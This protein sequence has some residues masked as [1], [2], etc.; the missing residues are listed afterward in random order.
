[1][2]SAPIH[3]L[4]CLP[5]R[6]R[7]SLH[8]PYAMNKHSLRVSALGFTFPLKANWSK[9]LKPIGNIGDIVLGLVSKEWNSYWELKSV[10]TSKR[11]LIREGF[12]LNFTDKSI[13]SWIHNL[14]FSDLDCTTNMSTSAKSSN[15]LV[16]I[17]PFHISPFDLRSR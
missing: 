3:H 6:W 9:S 15:F 1:M 7:H 14:I 11:L 12:V 16:L 8:F 10:K 17:F 5:R 2:T 4:S 13:R